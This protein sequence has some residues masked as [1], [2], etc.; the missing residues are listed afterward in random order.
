MRK[1]GNVAVNH[2]TTWERVKASPIQWASYP[3]KTY[4]ICVF[5]I[6]SSDTEK[7]HT[8]DI[9]WLRWGN[10]QTDC[11]FHSRVSFIL[12][13]IQLW[14]SFQQSMCDINDLNCFGRFN[15]SDRY[16][17]PL[18]ANR[19]MPQ[20]QNLDT[21]VSI[22]CEM[23]IFASD[24]DSTISSSCIPKWDIRFIINEINIASYDMTSWRHL[25]I[26]VI[27]TIVDYCHKN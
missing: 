18:Y 5:G 2:N 27:F 23:H 14:F 26:L 22:L 21:E 17:I 20:L 11:R 13:F 10:Y 4:I 16:G 3:M 24:P 12:I 8:L 1:S 15:C 9:R 25:I 7:K 6:D 19:G